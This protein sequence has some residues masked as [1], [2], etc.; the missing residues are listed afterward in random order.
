MGLVLL[1][2][3]HYACVSRCPLLQDQQATFEA[4]PRGRVRVRARVCYAIVVMISTAPL[5]PKSC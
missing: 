1:C 3:M 5:A 2:I 4:Q